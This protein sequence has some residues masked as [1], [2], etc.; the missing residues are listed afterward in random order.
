VLLLPENLYRA[1]PKIKE[2]KN[3]KVSLGMRRLMLLCSKGAKA[4]LTMKICFIG[5]RTKA[6]EIIMVHTLMLVPVIQ[7]MKRVIKI[8]FEGLLANS[9]AFC[10]EA[11]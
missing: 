7:N 4:W 8:C 11:L 5:F 2:L 1:A 6:I 3:M 10:R 9:Q